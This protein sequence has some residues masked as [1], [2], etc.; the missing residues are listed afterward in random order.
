M[1]SQVKRE[2]MSNVTIRMPAELLER[3]KSIAALDY[4][5]EAQALRRIIRLGCEA[6]ER[7]EAR[8]AERA[9]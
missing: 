7:E 6:A 2:P 8:N 3:V 5:R 1:E 9:S 4:S